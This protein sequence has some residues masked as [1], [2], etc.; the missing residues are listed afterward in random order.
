VRRRI[1]LSQNFLVNPRLV[2]TLLDRS[3]VG[4]DDVVYEIGPGTGAITE[5]LA[6]RCRHVIAVEK[7][8]RLAAHLG[9]RVGGRANVSLFLADFLAFPLPVT[10]YKVFANLPFNVTAAVIGR[11]IAAPTPPS[12]AYLVVQRE[13]AARFV[14]MSEGGEETLA[15]VLLKPWFEPT[16]AHRFQRADFAPAPGVDVVLLRLRK[17]GPP[18]VGTSDTQRY[19]DLVTTC[20]VAWQPTVGHAITRVLGRQFSRTPTAARSVVPSLA[21]TWTSQPTAVPFE[22]WLDLFRWFAGVADAATWQ[23]LS[24]AEKRLRQQQARLQKVHRT[25]V[26]PPPAACPTRRRRRWPH[27]AVPLATSGE[28]AR[29]A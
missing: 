14:G 6:Q 19:R 28:E 1:A 24:G 18:L 10:P 22:A 16:I 13:A 8:P 9:R 20:F 11:L 12:D 15:A 23:R 7:D 5:R 27:T 25:R 17:R 3:T 4:P 21:R 29:N 26:R 2:D